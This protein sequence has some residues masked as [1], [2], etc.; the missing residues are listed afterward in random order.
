MKWKS[1]KKKNSFRCKCIQSHTQHAVI[2]SILCLY[3]SPIGLSCYIHIYY[4]VNYHFILTFIPLE[5]IYQSRLPRILLE[6]AHFSFIFYNSECKVQSIHLHKVGYDH[7]SFFLPLPLTY[8]PNCCIFKHISF[9]P[10]RS[11]HNS[12]FITWKTHVK[13]S[14]VLRACLQLGYIWRLYSLL[15]GLLC[16]IRI[17]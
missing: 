8:K 15:I 9:P 7:Q 2:L 4:Q 1:T 10:P 16:Y 11:L 14:R 6:I 5:V 17:Y 12:P 13:T 3:S